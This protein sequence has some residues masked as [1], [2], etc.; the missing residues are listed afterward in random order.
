MAQMNNM[1]MDPT[2]MAPDA[3][4]TDA[5]V[6]GMPSNP[7]GQEMATPDQMTEIKDLMDK[8]EEKYRQMN[9]EAFAGGNQTEAQKKELVAEVFKALQQAGIDL[10]DVNA[11]RQFLDDLQLSNPDL[12]DL[13]VSSFEGLLGK[14]QTGAIPGDMAG[15]LPGALPEQGAVPPPDMGQIPG[16]VP[17]NPGLSGMVPSEGGITSQFPNLAKK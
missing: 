10:T 16:G 12:Y 8:I 15:A 4:A 17:S 11:V 3:V 9:A 5:G 7:T 13:F 1:P 2:A 14:E 6:P